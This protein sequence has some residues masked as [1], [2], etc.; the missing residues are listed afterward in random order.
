[1]ML[2]LLRTREVAVAGLILLTIIVV[3]C[4]NGDFLSGQNARDILIAAAPGMIVACGLTL[5]V[6]MGEIDISM[7][8]LMGLCAAVLGKLVSADHAALSLAWRLQLLRAGAHRQ[9]RSAPQS[10]RPT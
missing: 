3:S 8:A 2:S 4:V 7:G 5:V 10:P 6:V 1:M 9:S